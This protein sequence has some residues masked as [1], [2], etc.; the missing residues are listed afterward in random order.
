M[1]AASK[2]PRLIFSLSMVIFGT[3][4][5]FTRQ[6]GLP[7]GQIALFRALLASVFVGIVLLITRQKFPWRD[8]RKALPLLIAS[9]CA[10]GLNW[11][12]LFEAYRYTT[13]SVATLSYYFAPVI[14]ML[15][16]P[17][18]FREKWGLQRWLCFGL[19]TLGLA[20]I[21][22]LGDPAAASDHLLGIGFGLI[23]AVLY[24]TVML[25]NKSLGQLGG[26]HRTFFQFLFSLPALAVYVALSGGITLE[27]LS[28]PGG[29]CL[30]AVGLIHTGLAYCMYF[31]SLKD[32]PGQKVAILSYI[33]PLVAVLLSWVF[34]HEPLTGWQIAGGL[35]I[36]GS[37]LWNEISEQK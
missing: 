12:F 35:L 36:L 14:V 29:M 26:L 24:A 33:D 19:A 7:S 22:G 16:C 37:T 18:L 9:G 4:A 23:A 32:L 3:I 28:L 25:L 15:L 10:L 11:V 20:L 5:L 31:S 21:T 6:T 1:S 17:V 34:L 2:S 27:N 13:V 30:L 8:I